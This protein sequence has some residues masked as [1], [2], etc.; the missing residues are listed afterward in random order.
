MKPLLPDPQEPVYLL[1]LPTLPTPLQHTTV[2]RLSNHH[3]TW[4]Q[5]MDE[6]QDVFDV[7]FYPA[8]MIV[9]TLEFGLGSLSPLK[10][11]GEISLLCALS[12]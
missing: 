9:S 11:M 1:H 4:Q 12:L 2:S 6:S 8:E 3:K 5:M 10:K 7:S